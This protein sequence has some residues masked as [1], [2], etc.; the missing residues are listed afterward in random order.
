MPEPEVVPVA[1]DMVVAETLGG[2]DLLRRL[3]SGGMAEVHLARANG[4]EG[5]Q[6]LVVL[7]QILPHLSRD[8][9]FVRM[10]L[11]EA[12]L[13][14][15]LDHPNVV[16][17]YDLGK[18]E[19]EFFF[20]MEFVYGENL[21]GLLKA[22]RKV[23][24]VLSIENV[25]TIGLGVAAGLHYAHERVGFDGRPL[26]IVH[27]DVSPTNVM[28]TYEGGV[29]VADFGI[30][31][32]ITRT[33]VTRAGTRKGKVPYM[34]PEQCRAEKIDRR[35][36]VFSLGIV[37]W[38]MVTG[39]RLFE[40]DNEFGV[41]NLIVN[42]QIKSPSTVRADIPPA[43]EQI[44]MKALTVD[45]STRYQTARELQI[46]LET[47]A[48]EHKL[49]A[50]PSA[51][52]ELM[53][54][55][56]RPQPFPWGALRGSS[57][58]GQMSPATFAEISS[59]IGSSPSIPG[60]GVSRG[61]SEVT[62]GAASYASRVHGSSVYTGASIGSMAHS[63]AGQPKPKGSKVLTR[64]AIGLG[65]AAALA[66]VLVLGLWLG[67]RGARQEAEAEARKAADAAAE[68]KGDG[69]QAVE[70]AG[71]GAAVA[72]PEAGAE[73]GAPTEVEAVEAGVAEAGEAEAAEVG[74]AEADEAGAMEAGEL[75]AEAAEA[76]E[77]EVP[78]D[79]VIEEEII[80]EEIIEDDPSPTTTK[81]KK[82]TTTT[83]TKP[84]AT[85]KKKPDP[86]AFMPGFG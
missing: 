32:V 29:K 79:E 58:K 86:N 83:T 54:Y 60:T 42:G 50:T 5:F 76:G 48:C 6:K 11:E 77:L 81:K 25:V 40:G 72:A 56:F 63:Q 66:L 68:G 18:E 70:A 62:N 53:H 21:Q 59:M 46:A 19:G 24:Q 28:I 57:G 80:E 69:E 43:L 52:G 45:R 16:Q 12:R 10:F 39:Q 55:M 35:S 44:I 31:K 13:A 73:A 17:T 64:V 27:R 1:P 3:G 36:D 9:H 38:E 61:G 7:K 65:S 67:G 78:D 20:T 4:I 33:D 84:R 34:S 49:R 14:A 71:G 30:A 75:E 51:L 82:A 23:N 41:M 74:E 2:Y 37:L 8:K 15:L 47:F 26:G 22:L 85:K